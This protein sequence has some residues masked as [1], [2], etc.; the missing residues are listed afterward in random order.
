M[1]V[2]TVSISSDTLS[3]CLSHALSTE[4]EEIMGLLLGDVTKRPDGLLECRIW[5][6]SLH[7]REHAA[8]SDDR[9][10]INPEQ[11]AAASVEAERLSEE[12]GVHTR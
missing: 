1:S 4:T 8:R 11:L 3:V 6:V 7:Q 12:L 9:V 5:S 2:D 10:E